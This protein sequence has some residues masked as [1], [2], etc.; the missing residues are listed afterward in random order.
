MLSSADDQTFPLEEGEIKLPK[1]SIE[2]GEGNIEPDSVK[3]NIDEQEFDSDL[4]KPSE[5]V[6]SQDLSPI[7]SPSYAEALKKKVDSSGSSEDDGQFAKKFGR[8]SRKE[9]REEEAKGLKMQVS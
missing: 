8:K 9:V 6:C 2:E 5:E 3:A 4:V 1:T 7:R